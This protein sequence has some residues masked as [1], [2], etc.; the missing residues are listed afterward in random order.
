MA[1]MKIQISKDDFE[2][3]ILAATSSHSE[4]FESVEKHFEESYLRLSRQILGE[5]GEEALETSDELREA[6]IK[7][8]CLDAFLSVVRHLDLV[9]TPTGFGVVS[10]NEVT[11]AS[12]ARVEALIEQCRIALIVAQ[13]TVMALLTDVPGWGS[14]LQA[15]QGIQTVLWSIEGY[16]YLTRQTSMTSKDWM[17]KL[18][19]MQEADATLRKLVSDEQM[20]DIMCLVRGVREG[21]EFEGSVRLMLSRCL[22]MLANDML[23][24]Y[25]NERAR[26]LRYLDA[27]LDKFPLY[28]DSSAYK[29]NHFKEFNNEKSKPAFVFNA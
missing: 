27:H 23:S 29:A 18:A 25:S 10:N 16:C 17:A 15:K 3:S 20:D 28:A 8:V 6:V 7:T 22:I 2:Q 11:P 13:D 14:T 24:A 19:A 4:V 12:A 21:N 26:L 5:V 9:L 1:K